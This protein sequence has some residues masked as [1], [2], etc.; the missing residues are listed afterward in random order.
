MCTGAYK[1]DI[2]CLYASYAYWKNNIMWTYLSH[3]RKINV[4]CIP[5]TCKK[6]RVETATGL[7]TCSAVVAA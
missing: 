2:M 7:S 6:N 3:L 4:Y 5:Y 1:S